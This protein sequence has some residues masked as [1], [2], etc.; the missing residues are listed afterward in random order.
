VP[1][2][3][4]SADIRQFLFDFFNDA[5]LATLC[6]DFFP[7]VQDNFAA[8]MTKQQK[9]LERLGYCQRREIV[10]NLLAAL[11]RVRPEPYNKRFPQAA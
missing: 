9:I 11:Q 8:G 3:P 1:D 6:F 5:E 2:L 10:P 7:E 4:N